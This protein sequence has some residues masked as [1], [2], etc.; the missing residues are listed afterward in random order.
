MGLPEE[1]G[2]TAHDDVVSL[3]QRLQDVKDYFNNI[4]TTD[5]TLTD[6]DEWDSQEMLG[7]A[8]WAFLIAFAILILIA[9]IVSWV[10]LGMKCCCSKGHKDKPTGS[11]AILHPV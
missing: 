6:K 4:D 1:I 3:M 8:G 2:S 7:D 11:H 10:R 5:T 9:I